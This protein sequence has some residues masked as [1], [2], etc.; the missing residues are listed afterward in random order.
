MQG[1]AGTKQS[2][3]DRL[4]F[5]SFEV[6]LHA[7]EVYCKGQR[8]KLQEQPFRVLA[9]LLERPGEIVTREALRRA[10]WPEHTFVDFD[11]GLNTVIRKLRTALEDNAD[12]PQFIET[13]PRRGYR[14]IGASTGSQLVRSLAV[15]PFLNL[16]GD[17]SQEYFADGMTDTLITNL[18][19][20][21]SL[22]VISRTSVMSYKGT[23]KPLG[24]VARE[25]KVD[26]ILTGSVVRCGNRL[27]VNAQLI[28]AIPELHLWANTYERDTSD[29]LSLQADVTQ[30][31][32]A[33]IELKLTPQEQERLRRIRPVNAAAYEAYIS[34]RYY[35]H[36]R[37]VEALQT[38][39][40]YFE[41]AIQH[42]PEYALAY[43]GLADVYDVLGSGVAV[44]LPPREAFR[45]AKEAATHAISLDD[46]LGEAHTSLAGIMF[47]F[48]W[49]WE[50][51]E[52]EFRRAIELNRND[53]TAHF[54]YAQLLE[55][56]GRWDEAFA[57]AD[58]ATHLDPVAPMIAS[59][60]ASLFR[61]RRQ[62][63]TALDSLQ[64]ALA[65]DPNYFLVYYDR[66]LTYEQMGKHQEAISDLQKAGELSGGD[67]TARASLAHV[68]AV[69]GKHA[70]A[71]RIL[72]ELKPQA[73]GSNLSYQ[74]ADV[75]V[76][77]G[78]NEEA[79]QW[80][81]QAYVQRSGWLTWIAIEPK[82]DPL[83]SDNRFANLLDRM[84]L[85][86]Q[87][88]LA[89]IASRGFGRDLQAGT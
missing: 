66:G 35:W 87:T 36:K 84:R 78:R 21:G 28:Q 59:F 16:S 53:V 68:Y 1:A 24:E 30:A 38:A 54:W 55:A 9:M 65:L 45:K 74:I 19:R 67:L 22:R 81:E 48:D 4:R 57:S 80:L 89:E 32:A 39:R 29:I 58:R 77:L 8:I 61:A 47:S 76:G 33:E 64:K 70:E 15:L 69:S 82:L 60:R 52:T 75:Y 86:A 56:L 62:Y 27:R 73:E 5:G 13:L 20:I 50:G 83:R 71:E 37:T 12:Q 31:I 23:H 44:G 14:F 2:G 34:G 42:D 85:P 63:D 7:S 17:G 26:A 43:A 88:A 41:E 72:D 40:R 3:G 49:D 6:D 51:A 18:A 79:F 11:A 46:N 10:L 25:L